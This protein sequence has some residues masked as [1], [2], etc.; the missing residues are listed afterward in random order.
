MS[1]LSHEMDAGDF[2][3]IWRTKGQN[4]LTWWHSDTQ[5]RAH[6]QFNPLNVFTYL[7]Y[8]ASR[9]WEQA[10]INH[11]ARSHE[12]DV[13]FFPLVDWICTGLRRKW[14]SATWESFP[15]SSAVVQWG[16][17]EAEAVGNQ[18]VHVAGKLTGVVIH[19]VTQQGE[20]L[21]SRYVGCGSQVCRNLHTDCNRNKVFLVFLAR[22]KQLVADCKVLYALF[23]VVSK[24]CYEAI[25]QHFFWVKV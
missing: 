17:W 15:K 8:S 24:W 12:S 11:N 18:R 1:S 5:R 3:L 7:L 14:F 22:L 13:A 25:S 19:A 20:K 6:T 9:T 2:P 16:R 23:S 10:F 4:V 21:F